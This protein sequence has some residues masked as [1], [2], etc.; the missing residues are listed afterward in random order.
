M[1]RIRIETGSRTIHEAQEVHGRHAPLVP[2]RSRDPT[3][4]LGRR[5]DALDGLVSRVQ[6][7]RDVLP[8]RDWIEPTSLVRL[9]PDHPVIDEG[10]ARSNGASEVR[11]VGG[12]IRESVGRLT[13]VRPPRCAP[14]RH[15]GIEPP[16]VQGVEQCVGT[17]PRV[18]P[19]SPLDV[20]PVDGDSHDLEPESVEGRGTRAQCSRP[21]LEPG[22]ILNTESHTGCGRSR[23]SRAEGDHEQGEPE[24]QSS[25]SFD[26]TRKSRNRTGCSKLPYEPSR[27][28]GQGRSGISDGRRYFRS[29][30]PGSS[31]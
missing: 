21:V 23:P 10:I 30:P 19:G 31:P 8:R 7:L 16:R 20:V 27:S 1:V 29:G 13:F 2:A 15:D 9:V 11:K 4:D 12:L 25:H 17:T 18:A 3:R 22:V 14:E 26:G 5:G 28:I 24:H 6:K